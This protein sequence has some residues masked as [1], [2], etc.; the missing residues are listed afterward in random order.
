M[1][2]TLLTETAGIQKF[3]FQGGKKKAAGLYPLSRI[4]FSC[5][6]RPDSELGKLTAADPQNPASAIP[7]DPLRSTIA[8]FL[9]EVL[10]QTCKTEDDDP[11][12]FA[13]VI[14]LIEQL[15]KGEKLSLLPVAALIDYTKYL[16]IH[17]NSEGL[18]NRYFLLDEGEFRASVSPGTLAEEG[19]HVELIRSLI[20]NSLNGTPAHEIRMRALMTM[21]RYYEVHIPSFTVRKPL[22]ILRETLA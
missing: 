15:E 22:E 14:S 20:N 17:P 11:A 16:G 1:I 6:R 12:L 5:Y 4:E 7:F 21:I 19:Q 9:A 2:L 13:Y 3:V 18:N 8:F 10:L